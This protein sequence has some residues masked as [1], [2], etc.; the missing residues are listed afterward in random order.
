MKSRPYMLHGQTKKHKYIH[1]DVFFGVT[2]QF[3][4]MPCAFSFIMDKTNTA[5]HIFAD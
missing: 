2:V 3:D 1:N 5:V 4:D